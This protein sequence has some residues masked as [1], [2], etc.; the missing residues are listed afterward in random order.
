LV[1]LYPEK[2]DDERYPFAL[3]GSAGLKLSK[4]FGV[5]PI[6]GMHSVGRDLYVVN[7][8]DVYKNEVKITGSP[9]AGAGFVSID[10]NNKFMVIVGGGKGYVVTFATNVIAQITDLD[11]KATD[12][13]VYM[14]SRF[15]FNE[16]GSGRAF[17]SELLDPFSYDALDF[18][19]AENIPDDLIGVY[20]EGDRLVM[21]GVNSLEFWYNDGGDGFPFSYVSNSGTIIGLK[22]PFGLVRADNTIFFI[23]HDLS[24]YRMGQVPTK[25]STATVERSI[26][27]TSSQ[28]LAIASTYTRDGHLFIIFRFDEVCWIYDLNTQQWHERKSYGIT[29][30]RAGVI[31]QLDGL[32]YA[33][34]ALDGNLYLIDEETYDENGAELEAIAQ[35]SFLSNNQEEFAFKRFRLDMEGGVGTNLGQGQDPQIMMQYTNDGNNWS[36]EEWRDIGNIGEY[37][38]ITQWNRVMRSRTRAY[39]ITITDPVKRAIF[40]AWML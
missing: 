22:S 38:T 29:S 35:S 5:L 19:T 32:V 25:I 10:S 37:S 17:A 13:V 39:R 4:N 14:N 31:H 18:A 2:Q 16:S 24:I 7:G 30:W 8:E 21:A 27:N 36:F 34:S 23:G 12:T 40:G 9:I 3:F 11:F 33:G 6:R 26:R 28:S 20:R 1:N 15:I